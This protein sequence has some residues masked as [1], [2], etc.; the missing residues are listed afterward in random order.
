MFLFYY[1]F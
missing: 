1:F